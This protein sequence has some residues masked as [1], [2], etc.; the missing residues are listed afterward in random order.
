MKRLLCIISSM[1]AGGAE[2][3]IMKLYRKLDRSKYQIDFCVNRKEECFYDNE[4]KTLGGQIYK[5]P[6]KSE[7]IHLFKEGLSAIVKNNHYE[8][9][10]RITSNAMGFYD[11]KI[12]KASGAKRC[13][14]RSSNSSDGGGI[15]AWLAHLAGKVLYRKYVDIKI[16]PSDLAAEYTFGKK[17]Y[18]N[19]EVYI[20]RN[21]LDFE[22]YKFD[23]VNRAIVRGEFGISDS[24]LVIGHIGRFNQQKNHAFLIRIFNEIL[25]IKNDSKLFLVGNGIL[26]DEI[27]KTVNDYNIADKVIFAGVRKDISN[28]MSAFD[29]FAFPSFYEGMPNVIIEA[30]ANGLN[31]V[32]SDTVTKEADITGL[33]K[34]CSLNDS[35]ERWAKNIL[36]CANKPRV[37]TKQKFIKAGYDIESSIKQFQQI[38]FE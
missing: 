33:L 22:Q 18:V 34:Y 21:A 13:I 32:L 16:A 14:A 25:K 4:I 15:K 20:F 17:A 23:E 10:L 3:F 29:V 36:D 6:S 38:V 8:Y 11:L 19:G 2:T 27:K 24:T 1:N 5:I 7:N 28:V 30:Q 31:C 12:A 9:V 26:E 37:D 35:A